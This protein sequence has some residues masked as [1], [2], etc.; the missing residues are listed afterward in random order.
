MFVRVE[1]LLALSNSA[2]DTIN[3]HDGILPYSTINFT[4]L[5][6]IFS[7]LLKHNDHEKSCGKL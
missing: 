2:I 1:Y 3:Q 7:F 4:K 6:F 5:V